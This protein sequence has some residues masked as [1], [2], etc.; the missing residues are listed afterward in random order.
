[1]IQ[2]IDNFIQVKIKKMIAVK[3]IKYKLSLF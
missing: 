2:T 3:S 1:M